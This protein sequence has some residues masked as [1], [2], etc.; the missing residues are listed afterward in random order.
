M[1]AANDDVCCSGP[2]VTL[3]QRYRLA[4]VPVEAHIYT[5]GKHGFNMGDRSELKSVNSWPQ[6]MADWMADTNL[7]KA[8]GSAHA[9]VNK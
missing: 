1:L 9:N 7:L 5:Q 3:L 8:V 4:K 6:R 2:V